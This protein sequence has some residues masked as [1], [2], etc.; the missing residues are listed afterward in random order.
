[1]RRKR[2]NSAMLVLVVAAS[3]G[4][5][6]SQTWTWDAATP[7]SHAQSRICRDLAGDLYMTSTSISS[8]DTLWKISA[9]GQALGQIVFPP[10]AG[11]VAYAAAPDTGVFVTGAFTGTM[12]F[13]SS[14]YS[15][16]GK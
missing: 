3:I 5:L 10:T 15:A 2:T 13:A 12:T 4:Q 7:A 14:T 8:P 16:F 6:A 1:M 9:T 11:V